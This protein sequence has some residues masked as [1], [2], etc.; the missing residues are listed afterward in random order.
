MFTSPLQPQFKIR[1]FVGDKQPDDLKGTG[2]VSEDKFLDI[3][4]CVAYPVT[5]EEQAS[6]LSTLQFTVDKYADVLLYYFQIGQLVQLFGGYYTENQ[7]S[8][9]HVFSGTVTRIRT[10]FEETGQISFTVE[11]MNYG[12]VKMGKDDKNFVYP[13][14]NSSRKFAQNSSLSVIDIIK[15]IAKENNLNTKLITLSTEAK[16]INFDKVNIQYQ[17]DMTDWQYIN[18]LADNYGCTA[19]IST[20]NGE[21][22][23][24]FAPIKKASETV[25]HINF[26]FPLYGRIKDINDT[27]I[28][29][30]D[31]PTYDRPRILRDVSVDEDISQASAV[32]RSS[33]YYDKVTGEY[34]ESISQITKDDSGK[35]KIVFY[36][37]DEEKVARL[38]REDPDMAK[39]I[40]DGSPTGMEWGDPNN[41]TPEDLCYYFKVKVKY[42]AETSVFD[43][44]FFGITV[45]AKC[46]QDLDIKSQMAYKVR[47]ILSYFNKNSFENL[48]FLR[49]LKHIWDSD[50]TW[51]ELDFIR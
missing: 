37:F 48:F 12:Y 11:C 45:S 36:E 47:G 22:F 43:K 17:K 3:E 13:D 19:W 15:G 7:N 8:L 27:E 25:S 35:R 2:V 39:K 1:I 41:P 34:K 30:A 16:K 44:A 4:R 9:K 28:Q 33:M 14:A 46:N 23:L 5:Y 24:N 49:G 20:E 29:R 18:K 6:L 26:L 10:R 32:T 21:D 50:G 31:D 42:D 40:R 51:T 38:D